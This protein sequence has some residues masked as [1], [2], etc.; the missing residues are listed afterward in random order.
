MAFR[1]KKLLFKL[2]LFA[3]FILFFC[4]CIQ[5]IDI[6]DSLISINN[7]YRSKFDIK[8]DG[9]GVLAKSEVGT[10]NENV[11]I[12]LNGKDISIA[13]NGKY[14]S[15]FLKIVGEEYIN[16]NLNSPIDPCV[17]TPNKSD[18]F[19]YLVLPVRINA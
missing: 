1:V 16:L 6:G 8:E 19:L 5:A 11:P 14:I 12:N 17:I 10:V 9:M 18:G 4:T 3:L 2:L 15:E 7:F 13:F